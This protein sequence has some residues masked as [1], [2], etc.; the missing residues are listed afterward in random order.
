MLQ[1]SPATEADEETPYL[2]AIHVNWGSVDT[3]GLP[4]MW[5]SEKEME[6]YSVKNGDLLVCEGGEAGR[7]C[8]LQGL[9]GQAII[10]NALHRVRDTQRG[11]VRFLCYLLKHISDAGWFSI[12]CNKATIAHLTGEKISAIKMPVPTMNEQ[13]QISD[14]LEWKTGQIDSLIAKKKELIEKLKEKRIVLITQAVSKGLNPDAPMRDSGIPWLGEVPKHWEVRR[15]KFSCDITCGFAFSSDDFSIEG[16]PLIR[17]S[18]IKSTGHVS[19]EAVKYL[20]NDY[21]IKYKPFLIQKSDITMAMTGATI[22][23][24]AIY[25]DENPALLNQRCC[26]FRAHAIENQR[27]LWFVLNSEF[28]NEH[29]KLI[30]FGG[31]Q[32]N[33]SDVQL[34][35]CFSPHP[36]S[37][38]Q[39]Q[40]ADFL[41]QNTK[42]TDV[43]IAKNE[44][45]IEKLTEYR[46]ALITAAVTG[47]IDVRNVKIGERMENTNGMSLDELENKHVE[48]I[49]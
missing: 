36:P 1:N 22:G 21:G 9:E 38:E 49:G 39:Q 45:L 37:N 42:Q 4:T 3:E 47:K 5:A 24:A 40:I 28:Y 12:L 14:F 43:L 41:N 29:V 44:Q 25:S 26:V 15:L 31:A 2:K 23:K 33:I 19:L 6:I 35:D 13:Q 16:I 20:P 27:F 17:I 8:I 46:T 10:Q 11:S 32:P 30:G 7:A 18:D 34:L 48:I